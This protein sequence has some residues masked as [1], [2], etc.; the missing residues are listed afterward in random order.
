MRL[1]NIYCRKRAT[2]IRDSGLMLNFGRP[3][4]MLL[5]FVKA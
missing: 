1:L 3:I 2:K 5:V 4:K